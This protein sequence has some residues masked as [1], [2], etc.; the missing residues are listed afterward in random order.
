MESKNDNFTEIKSIEPHNFVVNFLLLL[1]DGRLVSCLDYATIKIFYIANDCHC[2][3]E[4]K[5]KRY[6]SLFFLMSA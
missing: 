3:I 2:D 5:T 4:I 6:C 1:K